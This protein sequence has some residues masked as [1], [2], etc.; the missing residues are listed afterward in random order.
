MKKNQEWDNFAGDYDQKVYS[1]TS[2]PEKR[3]RIIDNIVPG[4]IFIAGTGSAT[5]LNRDLI[6]NPLNYVVAADFNAEMFRKAQSKFTSPRMIYMYADTTDLPFFD[7]FDTIISTNSILPENPEQVQ[8]M[9]D[10]IYKSLKKGG[11]FVV[12]L[13]SFD[14]NLE[15]TRKFPEYDLR[16]DE[17]LERVWDTTGWQTFQ[18][19][20][21]LR[22]RLAKSNFLEAK[23]QKIGIESE[24]EAQVM[25][26]IYKFDYRNK[27]W[28]EYFVVASK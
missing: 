22:N 15:L 8:A 18:T 9:F 23:I 28:F 5:Y 6:K 17:T 4:K 10:N 2:F 12:Y 20:I 16:L 21:S 14:A 11:K 26:D 7:E 25:E 13:P 3:K 1:I 19:E 24:K 27:D